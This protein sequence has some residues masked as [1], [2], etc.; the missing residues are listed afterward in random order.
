MNNRAC[1]EHVI[2][3]CGENS[4]NMETPPLESVKY[5]WQ[6][7]DLR[8]EI[9]WKSYYFYRYDIAY[10]WTYQPDDEIMINHQ[11]EDNG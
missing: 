10:V 8:N 5:S 4:V 3:M 7:E 1:D 9:W 6:R 11:I 2:S